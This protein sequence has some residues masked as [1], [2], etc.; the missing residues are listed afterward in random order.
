MSSNSSSKNSHAWLNAGAIETALGRESAPETSVIRDILDK[1]LAMEPLGLDEIVALMRVKKTE[2][3][4]LIMGT[5]DLLKQK[6]YG[7]RI[8]LT[9]P[10][11]IANDCAS[12]CLYCS[13][14]KSNDTVKRK[15]LSPYDVKE[16]GTKLMRQGH[17]RIVVSAGQEE[18][19]DAEY[20][21]EI[22]EEKIKEYRKHLQRK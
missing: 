7:D 21:A 8:V 10:L 17:K 2:D 18:T 20:Y 14:H 12:E 13:A 1:S 19:F 6:A 9:A 5:A 11:H 15:R 4:V 16:A 22:I 3:W